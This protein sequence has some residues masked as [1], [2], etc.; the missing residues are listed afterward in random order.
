MRYHQTNEG[1]GSVVRVQSFQG[2]TQPPYGSATRRHSAARSGLQK[3]LHTQP[4]QARTKAET[5]ARRWPRPCRLAGFRF[6]LLP[7]SDQSFVSQ[8]LACELGE[9]HLEP[10]VVVNILAVVEAKR[11][12]IDVAEQVIGFHAD[13]GTVDSALQQRPEVFPSRYCG[14]SHARIQ[15]RD[16]RLDVD[17]L[18]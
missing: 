16:R 2:S 18:R 7:A 12:L 13:V 4:E 9:N 15:S 5:K 3:T 6:R 10:P 1:T 14:H 17:T 8:A 11:L